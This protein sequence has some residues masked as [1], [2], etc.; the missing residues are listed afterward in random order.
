MKYETI[1]DVFND[2]P[3]HRRA[4]GKRHPLPFVLLIV[5]MGVLSGSQSL[6]EIVRFQENQRKNFLK[7]FKPRKGRLPSIATFSRVLNNLDV[8]EFEEKFS[9]WAISKS[10]INYR[11]TVNIDGKS[12]RSTLESTHD[13]YQNFKAVASGF[14]TQS[15]MPIRTIMYENK[16][17]SE[18]DAVEELIKALDI[19]GVILTMDALHC[20]KNS[21]IN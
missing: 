17:K 3:D 2:L 19:E 16:Q 21:K 20:K 11:S 6:R 18:I 1:I 12:I 8:H 9:K 10:N 5:L 15:G 4:E 7:H 13:K 14:A